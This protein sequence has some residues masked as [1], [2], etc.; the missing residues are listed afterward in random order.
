MIEDGSAWTTGSTLCVGKTVSEVASGTVEKE[1]EPRRPG[2]DVASQRTSL[3]PEFLE[4]NIFAPLRKLGCSDAR[5]L[6]DL[7][8]G[9]SPKVK[10]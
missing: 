1:A 5:E 3:E 10:V 7:R 6:A 8:R 2:R 9:N 4:D